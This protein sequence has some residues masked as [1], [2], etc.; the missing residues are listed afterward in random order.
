[1]LHSF[2]TKCLCRHLAQDAVGEK[3]TTAIF[4]TFVF[5]VCVCV[6]VYRHDH[7]TQLHTATHPLPLCLAQVQ[8]PYSKALLLFYSHGSGAVG[9][10]AP[11]LCVLSPCTA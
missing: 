5:A 11:W 4:I 1:M 3:L 9:R 7:T 10:R 6:R 2:I 8:N